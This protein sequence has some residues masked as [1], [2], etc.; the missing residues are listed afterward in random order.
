MLRKIL[1]RY[2]DYCYILLDESTNSIEYMKGDEFKNK[3][4]NGLCTKFSEDY[5]CRKYKA[6]VLNYI[7]PV[8]KERKIMSY[9]EIQTYI[10]LAVKYYDLDTFHKFAPISED[11]YNSYKEIIHKASDGKAYLDF[12]IDTLGSDVDNK[13]RKALKLWKEVSKCNLDIV[14]Y[15]PELKSIVSEESFK[16][17]LELKRMNKMISNTDID[18]VF[19]D[20]ILSRDKLSLKNMIVKDKDFISA[21]IFYNLPTLRVKEEIRDAL[22]LLKDKLKSD[23]IDTVMKAIGRTKFVTD[24]PREW[25]TV[26]KMTYKPNMNVF[27]VVVSMRDDIVSL[28]TKLEEEETQAYKDKHFIV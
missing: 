13:T 24:I 4:L 19:N 18:A 23:A 10:D 3:E 11:I 25:L 7:L 9:D 2:Y 16:R 21:T 27:I 22:K 5:W 14:P 12:I 15:I 8:C 1:Y 6:E 26:T 17:S 20:F 28:K